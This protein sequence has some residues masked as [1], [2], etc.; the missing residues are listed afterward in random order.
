MVESSYTRYLHKSI[1]KLIEQPPPCGKTANALDLEQLFDLWVLHYAKV[2]ESVKQLLPLKPGFRLI[3]QVSSRSTAHEREL[4]YNVRRVAPESCQGPSR[5]LLLR[6][7]IRKARL[8]NPLGAIPA[9]K[10]LRQ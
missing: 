8:L 4:S 10:T 9:P 5:R 7:E 3:P 2:S 1:P 6:H